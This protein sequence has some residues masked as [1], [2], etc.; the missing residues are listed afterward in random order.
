MDWLTFIVEMCRALAWPL[1]LFFIVLL[2]R[3]P[4]VNLIPNLRSAELLGTKFAFGERLKALAESVENAEPLEA[5]E[6]SKLP[7][8]GALTSV[9]P[10]D[11]TLSKRLEA[12][13]KLVPLTAVTESWLIVEDELRR[14]APDKENKT[15]SVVELTRDLANQGVVSRQTANIVEALDDL[16]KDIRL[17]RAVGFNASISNNE[18]RAYVDLADRVVQR[19]RSS[20]PKSPNP[21]ASKTPAAK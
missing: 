20:T 5:E 21:S 1:V 15:R 11:R 13:I 3:K 19:I 2:V 12:V 16:Y 18:A 8:R 10:S 7:E 6:V 9:K 17:A 4:L 14:F